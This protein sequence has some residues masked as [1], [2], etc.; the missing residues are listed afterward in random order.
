M[1]WPKGLNSYEIANILTYALNSWG[2]DD[3]R[4]S[5]EQVTDVRATTERPP[6][7]AQ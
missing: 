7:A 6:G 3:G 2:N 1:R 5:P 4:V